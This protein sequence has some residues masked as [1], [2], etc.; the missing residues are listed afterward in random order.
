MLK[1]TSWLLFGGIAGDGLSFLFFIGLARAF[2]E[3]AMGD[4]SF[5]F[6]VATLFSFGVNLS[7]RPLVTRNVARNHE[8]ASDYWG[9]LLILQAALAVAVGLLLHGLS[10]AA[11][12]SSQLYLLLMLAFIGTALRAIGLSFVALLEAVE[13]M[14]KS[15]IL[16]I[17]SKLIAVIFGFIL[18]VAGA[19][20]QAVMVAF[21]SGSAAY[22]GIALYWVRHQFRPLR[23]KIDVDLMKATLWSV[24]PFLGAAALYEV[25]ARADIVMLYHFI[26]DAETGRYAV[27]VRFITTPLASVYLVGVAMYPKLSRAAE[28]NATEYDALFLST[29]KWLAILGM[30]GAIILISSG[31]IVVKALFGEGFAG[32]GE[33]VRWTAVIFF[34]GFIRVPYERLLLAKNREYTQLRLYGLSVGL[35][36]V[37]NFSLIPMYGVYGAIWASI[38]SEVLLA[39]GLHLSCAK[40]VF[41]RHA[42][43]ASRLFL[44]GASGAL[45]GILLRGSAPWPIIA[46]STFTIFIGIS[47]TLRIITSKDHKRLTGALAGLCA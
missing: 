10:M 15:A 42:V 36:V 33:L 43:M 14:N 19:S 18:I 34:V 40:F 27:A 25:Y 13:A 6:A 30:A 3:S 5:A 2:G 47:M 24:L 8:L 17:V 45:T 29:L 23:F 35:N 31:D 44:A 26:G 38:L 39:V 32:S 1:N 4:Y 46:A 41:A 11:G 28:E 9:T 22:A 12:Y 20:L 7:L 37:L 21:V 16:D